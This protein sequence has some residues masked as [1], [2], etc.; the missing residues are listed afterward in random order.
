MLHL[1]ED[2]SAAALF[3]ADQIRDLL[4]SV[5]APVLMLATGSTPQPLYA[6]LR[7][8]FLGGTLSLTT[9]RT[10]N[11]DEYWPCRADSPISFRHFMD[12]ELFAHCD[13]PAGSIGFLD[14]TVTEDAIQ[15]HCQSYEQA[16][17][18]AGG[19]D[20]CLLGI[21]VNGHIA[22]NEPGAPADSRTRLVHLAESTRKRPGFPQGE[23]APTA[24][25]TVG[26]QTIM[27][28]KKIIVMAFGKDK[29]EP[30]RRALEEQVSLDTP[31]SL[32]HKHPAVTWVLDE[33]AASALQNGGHTLS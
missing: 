25:I 15:A 31:A 27:Q 20:L 13:L 3:V 21:G 8:R 14:G 6:V 1:T 28:S 16:I 33:A 32:L 19:I 4:A 5:P 10:F 17:E 30:V 12:Q 24:G 7:E 26:I 2:P 29:A 22:F 11:L 9:C 18:D 23:S